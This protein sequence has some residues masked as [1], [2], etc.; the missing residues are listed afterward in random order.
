MLAKDSDYSFHYV[1]ETFFVLK[2]SLVKIPSLVC[3]LVLL[4][5]YY[6]HKKIAYLMSKA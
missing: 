2:L 1:P 3:E 5:F 6:K 4:V